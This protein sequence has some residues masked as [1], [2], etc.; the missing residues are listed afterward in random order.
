MATALFSVTQKLPH[1]FFSI[2]QKRPSQKVQMGV[3]SFLS[4]DGPT[5]VKM[6]RFNYWNH[7]DSEHNIDF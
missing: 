5:T 6:P 1:V 4:Y 2:I 3:L 7:S